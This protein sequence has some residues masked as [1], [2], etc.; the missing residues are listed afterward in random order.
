MPLTLVEMDSADFARRRAPLIAGYA[1]AIT[2]SR[3]LT[4]AEAVA[5]AERDIAEKLPRGSA[6]PGLLMRKAEWDG[7]EIGWIWVTL[8]GP[9]RPELAWIGNIEVDPGFRSRGYAGAIITAVGAELAGLGVPRLGLNVFGAN[10][11]AIRVYERL[12]FEVYAQQRS[13]ELTGIPT[14]E[15]IELTPMTDY[16]SRIEALFADFAQDLVQE[17]GLWHGEAE[18]RA[19]RELA[20]LLP[21]GVRTKGMI[22]R[23]VAAD[24]VPVGWVWAGLPAPP[25]PGLGWLHNI[26]IDEA[27][28]G[29]GHGRAAIAAVE[30]ELAGRGV[31]RLGLNVHGANSGA[32]RLCDRLGYRLLAQQMAKDLPAR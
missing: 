17:Q 26:E 5:E 25:R 10:S 21:R 6:T 28:R 30:A 24:G 32:R 11:T 20:E 8:P 31:R 3:G 1:E 29:R 27:H 18:T 22:L 16:E 2:T 15:G 14:A 7:T 19:A 23:T 13:R 4:V 12:G 9:A